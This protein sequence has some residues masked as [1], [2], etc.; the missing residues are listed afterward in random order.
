[1][2][3]EMDAPGC[4]MNI[5]AAS[6]VSVWPWQTLAGETEGRCQLE[7]GSGLG[8]WAAAEEGWSWKVDGGRFGLQLRSNLLIPPSKEEA[9]VMAAAAEDTPEE[10]GS[11]VTGDGARAPRV[12]GFGLG[13]AKARQANAGSEKMVVIFMLGGR[14]SLVVMGMEYVLSLLLKGVLDEGPRSIKEF[15]CSLY[16][17]PDKT[18]LMAFKA[19]VKV[20]PMTTA[21]HFRPDNPFCDIPPISS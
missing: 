16:L 12:S 3:F 9:T 7:Y 4:R 17:P 13:D 2:R 14:R 5:A 18:P 1:M 21:E 19:V 6:F 11:L 10:A 8:E 20:S 15:T